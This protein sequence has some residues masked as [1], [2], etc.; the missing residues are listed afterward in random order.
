LYSPGIVPNVKGPC[1]SIRL[2]AM[3]DGIQEYEYL[4]LAASNGI[5]KDKIN[6]LVNSLVNQPFGEASMGKLDVWSYD[7]QKWDES[8]IRLGDMISQALT[9]KNK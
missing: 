7:P 1:P 9:N 8:R 5:S 6:E 3:R 2:K 4:R